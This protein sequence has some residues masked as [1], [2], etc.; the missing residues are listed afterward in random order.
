MDRHFAP[1][2]CRQRPRLLGRH[3]RP[4]PGVDP[5]LV[6]VAL[7]TAHAQ[8]TETV[9]GIRRS[10]ARAGE[11]PR[12]KA[13][14]TL[15]V[16]TRILQPVPDDLAGLRDRALLLLGF[17]GALRRSELAAVRVEHLELRARGLQLTLP[18]S[19]GVRS[20]GSIVIAIPMGSTAACPVKALYR[21][22]EAAGIRRCGVPPGLAAAGWRWP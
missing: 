17:A 8:V 19:K 11:R 13:A 10:A 3:R 9:A 16:L 20:G 22:L 6:G 4:A 7:P 15:A 1:F 2:W 12:K 5:H 14:A 21:W 18:T